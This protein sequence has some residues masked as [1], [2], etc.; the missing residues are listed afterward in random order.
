MSTQV[1]VWVPVVVAIVGLL[2]VLGAQLVAGWREDR[3]WRRE[4]EREDVRW[5][6]EREKIADERSYVAREHAYAQV[7]GLLEAWAWLLWPAKESLFAGRGV[8]PDA[9]EPLRATRDRA[10]E[11]LGPANL[12]APA[13]V[14]AAMRDA[15]VSKSDFTAGLLDERPDV[16]RLHELYETTKST[17]LTVRAAMRADLGVD[18]DDDPHDGRAG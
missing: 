1:P 7:I 17:Y 9:V 15:I 2:G 4:Q 3:R 16:A 12:H 5:A 11:V 10:S 6:R 18:P 14:R 13:A 8:P